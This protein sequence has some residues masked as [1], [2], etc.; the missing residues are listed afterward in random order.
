MKVDAR[1]FITRHTYNKLAKG[2]FKEESYYSILL[3]YC[4]SIVQYSV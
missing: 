2:Q 4:S 1:T 3:S